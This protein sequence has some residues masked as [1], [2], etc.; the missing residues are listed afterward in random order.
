MGQIAVP[1]T[2]GLDNTSTGIPARSVGSPFPAGLRP[3][4][5]SKRASDDFEPHPFQDRDDAAAR[6]RLGWQVSV[7]SALSMVAGAPG[8]YIAWGVIQ[9]SVTNLTIICVMIV[10]FILALVVPFPTHEDEQSEH[11]GRS[12]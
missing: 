4:D 8:K 3:A 7:M 1:R 2:N 5:P 6:A 10:L 9:I 12:R 11:E